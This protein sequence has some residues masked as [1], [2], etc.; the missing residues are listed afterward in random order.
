[1]NINDILTLGRMGYSKAEIEKMT[2]EPAEPTPAKAAEPAPAPAKAAE[3]APAKAAEPAKAAPAE[4]P[5]ADGSELDR[6]YSKLSELTA[7]LQASNRAAADMGAN[8]IDPRAAG[9]DA[10]ADLSGYNTKKED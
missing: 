7:A 5:K 1:M 9:V 2:E 4:P 3:P 6:L 8:I 10:L